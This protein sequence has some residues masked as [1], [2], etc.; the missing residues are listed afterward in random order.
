MRIL[1]VDDDPGTLHALQAGLMSLGYQVCAALGGNAALTSL[2][3]CEQNGEHI[4][5]LLTDFRMPGMDG[6]ELI[7]QCRKIM[8]QLPVILMSAYGNDGVRTF[9]DGP[10]VRFVGKPFTPK[11]LKASIDAAREGVSC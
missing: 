7:R 5:V 11:L 9:V 6:M 3:D 8:P 4:D 10:L 1:I 2:H